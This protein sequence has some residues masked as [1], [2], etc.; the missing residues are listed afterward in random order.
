MGIGPVRAFPRAP[1]TAGLNLDRAGV[2]E[3]NEAFAVQALAALDLPLQRVN[4]NGGP[5]RWRIRRLH[6]REARRP[7]RAR[8]SAATRSM[9]W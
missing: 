3:L 2:I 8:W 5:S 1:D 4:V 6:R 9:G 7:P